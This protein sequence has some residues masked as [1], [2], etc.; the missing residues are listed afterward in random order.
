MNQK[1]N[2][3]LLGVMGSDVSVVNAARVSFGKSIKRMA[4]KDRKLIRYLAAHGHQSPFFHPQLSFRITASIFVA[5]QLVKHQVG[6]TWNEISRR[7]VDTAPAYYMPVWRKRA[8][9]VKQGSGG[10]FGAKEQERISRVAH[11]AYMDAEAQYL[12]LLGLGVAPEQARV[13]LPLGMMTSWIWTGSLAAFA[14]VCKARLDPSA[15]AEAGEIAAEIDRQ[16]RATRKF[17]T[18][19]TELRK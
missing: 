19:W 16:I 8:P 9:N 12:Y 7:Y 15:Q 4:E 11:T 18:S 10:V 6:L 5:R 3:E 13:V 1:P 17:K 14:R 2:V